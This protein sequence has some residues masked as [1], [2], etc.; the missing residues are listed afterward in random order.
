MREEISFDLLGQRRLIFD[1]DGVTVSSTLANSPVWGMV[2]F[3][4]IFLLVSGAFRCGYSG[5]AGRFL[6][7]SRTMK[8]SVCRWIATAQSCAEPLRY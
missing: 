3:G 1:D 8:P 5:A 4:V 2:F 6:P 7:L